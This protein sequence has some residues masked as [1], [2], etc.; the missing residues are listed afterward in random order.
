MVTTLLFFGTVAVAALL[1]ALG[2][3]LSAY[4][5]TVVGTQ[6]ILVTK[7]NQRDVGMMWFLG[8][9]NSCLGPRGTAHIPA[10]RQW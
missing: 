5:A 2:E 3:Y 10:G 1:W 6:I 9:A 4:V 7:A 8:W